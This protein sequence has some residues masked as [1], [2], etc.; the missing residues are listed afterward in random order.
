MNDA[1][2]ISTDEKT[3]VAALREL[4]ERFVDERQWRKYHRPKN[5]AMSLAIEAAELMEHFQWLEHDQ[6]DA[7]L[8]E[9]KARRQIAEEMADVLAY[10]LSLSTATEID[11]STALAEKMD[12]N[13][14]KYPAEL[15]RGHYKRPE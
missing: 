6:A 14:E 12:R 9:P 7:A 3:S 15:V 10:L 2:D 8:A 4:V 11:L 13:A 1:P 5:L